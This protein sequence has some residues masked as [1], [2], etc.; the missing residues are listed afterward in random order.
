LCSARSLSRIEATTAI[1]KHITRRHTT[2]NTP[3]RSM[4]FKPLSTSWGCITILMTKRTQTTDAQMTK[5]H[6][7]NH[8]PGVCTD[9][10]AFFHRSGSISLALV[11]THGAITLPTSPVILRGLF[12]IAGPQRPW[13]SSIIA[14]NGWQ[15][16]QQWIL[17]P[18]DLF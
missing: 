11:L 5:K 13:I 2:A 9:G 17:L 18:P 6:N 7:P 16:A 4:S 8:C 14:L 10:S 12:V 1:R 15:L 3:K